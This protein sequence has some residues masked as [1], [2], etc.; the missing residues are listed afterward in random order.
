[1]RVL[2][3]VF[4]SLP[5]SE[6]A[7]RS[8]R[9]CDHHQPITK[10]KLYLVSKAETEVVTYVLYVSLHV[11]DQRSFEIPVRLLDTKNCTWRYGQL[12]E[13]AQCR[14]DWHH[15]STEPAQL[16]STA[17]ELKNSQVAHTTLHIGDELTDQVTDQVVGHSACIG[18]KIHK[19]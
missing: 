17:L 5:P 11:N 7:A 3:A 6:N 19:G 13:M 1:M 8:Y 10:V 2:P 16:Q 15:W 14:D 12:K 4:Y 9:S 18:Y